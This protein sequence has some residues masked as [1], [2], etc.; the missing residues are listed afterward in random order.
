[1]KTVKVAIVLALSAVLLAMTTIPA[2]ASDKYDIYD[3]SLSDWGVNP[4][5]GD[6]IPDSGAYAYANWWSGPA[7]VPNYNPGIEECDIEA[8]YVDED[9]NGPYIYRFFSNFRN[10]QRR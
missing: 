9:V 3:Q 4:A 7:N 10:E 1:M 5:L 2:M 8:I 6:W